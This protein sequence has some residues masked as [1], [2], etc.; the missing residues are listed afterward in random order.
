[1]KLKEKCEETRKEY[2]RKSQAFEDWYQ[3]YMQCRTPPDDFDPDRGVD[4]D[5]KDPIVDRQFQVE[6]L[7]KRLDEE[8]EAHQ[9]HCVQVRD[10]SLGSLKI[11]L[12]ELFRA[13]SD[14]TYSCMQGYENLRSRFPNQQGQMEAPSD[15]LLALSRQLLFNGQVNLVFVMK[16]LSPASLVV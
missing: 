11:R 14:Y 15:N 3:K 13:M 12:P 4:T 6:S 7:K 5:P 10:K 2:L 8:V 16:I 9:K 1:M